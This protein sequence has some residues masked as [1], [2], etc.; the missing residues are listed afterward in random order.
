M[1]ADFLENILLK[2]TIGLDFFGYNLFEVM[3]Y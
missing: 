2:L 1:V 3:K